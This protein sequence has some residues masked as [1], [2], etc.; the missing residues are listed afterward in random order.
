MKLFVFLSLLLV[1]CSTTSGGKI[2]Q[3]AAGVYLEMKPDGTLVV[4]NTRTSSGT[5]QGSAT[6]FWTMPKIE[7]GKEGELGTISFA[8]MKTGTGNIVLGLI[9]FG[10][11]FVLWKLLAQPMLAVLAAAAGVLSFLFPMWLGLVALGVSLIYCVYSFR[12][13]IVQLIQG[14]TKALATVPPV[15]KDALKVQMAAAHDL[16]TQAIVRGVQG[17]P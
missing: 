6:G 1:G 15:T 10:L 14:N 7:G 12:G 8:G 2:Q 17:K 16:T 11:A 13:V 9:L 5:T 3:K 4:D